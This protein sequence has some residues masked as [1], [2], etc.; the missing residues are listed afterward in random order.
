VVRLLRRENFRHQRRETRITAERI[1]HWVHLYQSDESHQKRAV[2]RRIE[3]DKCVRHKRP[4]FDPLAH[5]RSAILIP[6]HVA[7]RPAAPIL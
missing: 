2:F 1:K 5:A 4:A 3:T 7:R 6:I